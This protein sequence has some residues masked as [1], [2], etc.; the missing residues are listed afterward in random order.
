LRALAEAAAIF[1]GAAELLGQVL[2]AKPAED[3]APAEIHLQRLSDWRDQVA[4]KLAAFADRVADAKAK[5]P[6]F[7]SAFDAAAD[8]LRN[9]MQRVHE[10]SSLPPL[11][12]GT[13]RTKAATVA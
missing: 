4:A 5:Q 11:I 10:L 2:G 9:A 8:M 1:K 7:A 12:D 13:H 3:G 6:D